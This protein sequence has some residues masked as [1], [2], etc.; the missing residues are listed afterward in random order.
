MENRITT[1]SS[2][3]N[4]FDKSSYTLDIGR[5][6][7]VWVIPPGIH[8]DDWLN[9]NLIGDLVARDFAT[10]VIVKYVTYAAVGKTLF[11]L[12]LCSWT[13]A[14]YSSVILI[15]LITMTYINIFFMIKLHYTLLMLM[16]CFT[17][18]MSLLSFYDCIYWPAC[19]SSVCGGS[20]NQLVRKASNRIG[21]GWVR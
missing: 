20:P 2:R 5:I 14:A 13:S 3:K 16:M 9:W 17:T 1:F 12:L 15:Y 18:S 6:H 10:L 19:F 4:H 21:C 8:L 7:A 11:L